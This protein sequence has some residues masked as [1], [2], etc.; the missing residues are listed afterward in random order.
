[1]DEAEW[2]RLDT[3]VTEQSSLTSFVEEEY[4]EKED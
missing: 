1:M 2:K 4:E 3:L